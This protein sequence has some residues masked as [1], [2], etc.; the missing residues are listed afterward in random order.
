MQRFLEERFTILFSS[1]SWI[2]GGKIQLTAHVPLLRFLPRNR[3][4][5]A[6]LPYAHRKR[7]KNHR[8]APQV[9]QSLIEFLLPDC[10]LRIF[11]RDFIIN[12]AKVFRNTVDVKSREAAFAKWRSSLRRR[13]RVIRVPLLTRML[14]PGNLPSRFTRE[15]SQPFNYFSVSFRRNKFPYRRCDR[16]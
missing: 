6:R 14:T 12:T 4:V 5:G 13:Y 2:V 15:L 7:T 3:Q 16:F 9:T 10:R 11:G 1:F 8:W